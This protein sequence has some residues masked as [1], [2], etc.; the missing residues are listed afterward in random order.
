MRGSL[1]GCLK[2]DYAAWALVWMRE[3]PEAFEYF[4]RQCLTAARQGRRF[5]AKAIAER[6]RWEFHVERGQDGFKLNNNITAH[7]IRHVVRK[8]PA[9]GEFVEMREK[10]GRA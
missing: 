10:K 5:G 9:V 8:H 4:E 6:V 7:L 1:P 2:G 3:N